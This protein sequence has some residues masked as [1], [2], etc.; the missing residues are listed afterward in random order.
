MK[1]KAVFP[2]I[3]PV[4]KLHQLF[5]HSAG[6]IL[7]G[8][9]AVMFVGNVSGNGWVSPRDPLLTIPMRDTLWGFSV[10]ALGVALVCLFGKRPSL[11]LALVLWL[12]MNFAVYQVGLGWSGA[13]GGF[14]GYLGGVS[15]AFDLSVGTTARLLQFIILYLF[16]GSLLSLV[17]HW[18]RP[19][20]AESAAS[21]LKT[22]C[23]ACG[24]HIRFAAQNLGQII[25][26]PHCQKPTR[27]RQADLLKISCF[28]C[29][30]HIEFPAHAIGE[31]MH[32]PHCKMDIT[33]KEPA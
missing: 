15:A 11:Q 24:G 1:S 3:A 32:C 8:L 23:T 7:L 19:A 31:K 28:F 27:L 16:A 12:A 5:L 17:W 30:G 2:R 10:L 4:P 6:A 25:N 18:R 21:E 9:A 22:S 14:K 13:T 20:S 29:Q 26:C 33:L